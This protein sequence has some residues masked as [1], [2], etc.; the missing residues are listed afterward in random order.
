MLAFKRASASLVILSLFAWAAPVHAQSQELYVKNLS[1]NALHTPIPNQTQYNY[2]IDKLDPNPQNNPGAKLIPGYR[3]ANQMV[4]YTAA[5]HRPSTETNQAGF[6]ATLVNGVIQS[7]MPGNSPIPLDNGAVLS[8]HGSAALWLQRFAQPG[9]KALYDVETQEIH[10]QFTPEVYLY[11]VD[12][13][14]AAAKKALINNPKA[15]QHAAI[16]LS[17]AQQCRANITQTKLPTL[18]NAP[19]L[20]NTLRI[21]IEKCHEKAQEAYYQ[22]LITSPEELR[23]AWIRPSSQDNDPAK[24]NARLQEMKALGINTIF[25]ETYYQGKTIF[26]SDT[27]KAVGLSS[28]HT[29]FLT[30]DPLKVWI[31]AAHANGMHLHAWT[32]IFF[33]GNREANAENFGPILHVHPEWANIQRGHIKDGVPVASE[34][35]PGHYF[36]DP[37]NPDVRRFLH[38]LLTEIVTHYNVDGINLDYIRYPASYTLQTP[39]YL[40]STWGYTPIARKRFIAQIAEEHRIA[41]EEEK[42]KEAEAFAQEAIMALA[43]H[44]Q[45]PKKSIAQ[46]KPTTSSTSPK[47]SPKISDDPI[48]LQLSNPIW[49]RWVT[50]RKEQVSSFVAETSSELHQ[51][52]SKL[53]LSAVVFPSLDPAYSQKLQDYPRW[54]QSGWIQALTP[55]GLSTKPQLMTM[56]AKGIR[57]QI[58]DKVPVYPGVFSLYNRETPTAMVNEIQAL[59]EAGVSGLVFF[60][61]SRLTPQYRNALEMGPFRK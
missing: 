3:A 20:S 37:A 29:Q 54:V 21:D 24:L 14:I 9:A 31:E 59:H 53:L 49:L 10:I 52:K 33:A 60:D 5:S 12:S 23:G 4:L 44:L 13:S 39:G 6:E 51:L 16:L 17:E 40:S 7:T 43:A 41:A 45:V 61:F 15:S 18:S 47:I 28:Q 36:L 46:A 57:E 26:P 34:I 42:R 11:Q 1:S 25:L 48:D 35:E 55:I 56:Q 50:W 32:Q 30:Q 38:N 8:G 27:M 2:R 22:T 58:Q 19:I